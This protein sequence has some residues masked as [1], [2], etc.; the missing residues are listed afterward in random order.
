MY[1]LKNLP[2][3]PKFDPTGTRTD[4]LQIIDSTFNGL[5]MD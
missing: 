3:H 5:Q 2:K 1:P 4:D